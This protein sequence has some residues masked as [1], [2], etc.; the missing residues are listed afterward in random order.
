MPS[1]YHQQYLPALRP[2]NI[3]QKTKTQV[4]NSEEFAGKG[5]L[6]SVGE[7]EIEN[8]QE[9]VYLRNV[10]T[11]DDKECVTDHQIAKA[12]AKFNELRKVLTGI[13]VNMNTKRK[14]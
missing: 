5:T 9:F 10:I 11:N 7:N 3:I 12:M 13:N 6:I 8:I 1:R 2:D 14:L 4:F